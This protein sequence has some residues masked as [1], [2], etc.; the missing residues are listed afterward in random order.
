MFAPMA[1]WPAGV[2]ITN[3]P[4]AWGREPEKTPSEESGGG[5]R[6]KVSELTG[7]TGTALTL[8]LILSEGSRIVFPLRNAIP[9]P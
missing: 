1:F 6:Q 3:V 5:F 7:L 8:Y 9:A 4:E 2:A